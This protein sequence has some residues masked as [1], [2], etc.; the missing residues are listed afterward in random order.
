MFNSQS[1]RIPITTLSIPFDD[2]ESCFLL[3]GADVD[4]ATRAA[5]DALQ[6]FA[7]VNFGPRQDSG[8]ELSPEFSENR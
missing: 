6:D 5:I 8:H 2:L 3:V 4:L 7:S 1:H